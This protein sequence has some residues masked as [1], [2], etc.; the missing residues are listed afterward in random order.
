MFKDRETYQV[1]IEGSHHLYYI[2]ALKSPI[3]NITVAI[4]SIAVGIIDTLLAIARVLQ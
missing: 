2:A 4:S 1:I 3:A